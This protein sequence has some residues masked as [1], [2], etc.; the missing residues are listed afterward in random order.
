[1][2]KAK[3]IHSPTE[4]ITPPAPCLNVPSQPW[5]DE[6][7]HD[8]SLRIVSQNSLLVI[9]ATP[10]SSPSNLSHTLDDLAVPVYLSFSLQ[11]VFKV[12]AGFGAACLIKFIGASRDVILNGM[13]FSR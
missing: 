8:A 5:Q 9:H 10:H 11:P 13:L 7:W 1:M 2:N 4:T 12:M 6:E 3:P